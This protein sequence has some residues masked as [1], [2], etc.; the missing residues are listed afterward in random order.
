M[1]GHFTIIIGYDDIGTEILEDDVVIVVDPFDTSDHICDGYVIWS[2]ERLYYQM[3]IEYL[4]IEN[5]NYEFIK[6]KK[7]SN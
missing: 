1:A 7:K 2:F 5:M 6:V 4:Y 3:A